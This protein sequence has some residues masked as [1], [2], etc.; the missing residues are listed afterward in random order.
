MN[1]R[2]RVN[3][4]VRRPTPYQLLINHGKDIMYTS[5]CSGDLSCLSAPSQI[6]ERT[7]TTESLRLAVTCLAATKWFTRF[8]AHARQTWG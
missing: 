4:T 6:A 7:K 2:R 3:S 5:R 1:S 8:V